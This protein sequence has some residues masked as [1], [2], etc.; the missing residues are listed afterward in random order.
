MQWPFRRN[1]ET[2]PS[3]PR[4]ACLGDLL[5]LL[6]GWSRQANIRGPARAVAITSTSGRERRIVMVGIDE[7]S[8]RESAAGPGRA[9]AMPT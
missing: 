4:D 8:A 2:G 3:A 9:G 5:G 7:K 1:R 6:F